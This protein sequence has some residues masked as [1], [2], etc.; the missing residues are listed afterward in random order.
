[1]ELIW[2]LL[3]MFYKCR[4]NFR[5]TGLIL[6]ENAVEIANLDGETVLQMVL[7]RLT[8]YKGWG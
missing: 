8:D 6:G 1:M 3:G 2:L 4:L 7:S 5:Q